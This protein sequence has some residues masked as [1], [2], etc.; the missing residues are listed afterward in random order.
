MRNG[1]PAG[2]AIGRSLDVPAGIAYDELREVI[3]A[4]DRVH[5]DGELPPVPV[6]LAP[7]LPEL[8]QFRFDLATGE[9]IGLVVRAHQAYRQLTLL[10][11]IGHLIDW[12]IFGAKTTFGS[13]RHPMLESWLAVVVESGAYRQLDALAKR[14]RGVIDGTRIAVLTGR[15]VVA[16]GNALLPDECWARSYAPYVT[17][18]STIPG[19]ARALSDLRTPKAGRVYY[20]LQWQDDDFA[21]IAS[22]IDDLFGALGWR[23]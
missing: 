21:P 10:H 7:G 19:L 14:G 12:F 6:R 13:A 20:P 8:G 3:A 15:E 5:G 9:P 17:I 22:A 2:I 23:T 1:R 18:H 4:I 16:A 11:E